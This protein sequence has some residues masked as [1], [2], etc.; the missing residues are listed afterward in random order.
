MDRLISEDQAQIEEED[1]V[2]D[3]PRAA[4]ALPEL[5]L[6][7]ISGQAREELASKREEA[8]KRLHHK[9]PREESG[10]VECE[11]HKKQKSKQR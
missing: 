1:Q 11:K 3:R 8:I 9:K 7:D 10:Q 6:S 4:A 2:D 5:T